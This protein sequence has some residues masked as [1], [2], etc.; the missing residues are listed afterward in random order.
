[1]WNRS[2]KWRENWRLEEEKSHCKHLGKMFSKTDFL[3]LGL[4]PWEINVLLCSSNDDF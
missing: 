1:M 3:G 4:F 2:G